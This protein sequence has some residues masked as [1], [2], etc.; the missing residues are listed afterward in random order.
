MSSAGTGK[1]A[2]KKSKVQVKMEA[3]NKRPPN[4]T[5]EEDVLISR[6]FV[7]VSENPT[8]GVDQKAADFWRHVQNVFQALYKDADVQVEDEGR[9]G[10]DSQAIRNRF[11][12]HI[13]REVQRWNS[14]YKNIKQKKR[15]GAR[16]EDII[17]AATEE[18]LDIEGKPFWFENCV[19][20]LQEMPKFDPMVAEYVDEELPSEDDK[21]GAAMETRKVAPKVNQI[22]APMGA[23]KVR[24]IGSKTAKKVLL[25]E[26]SDAAFAATA[27]ADATARTESMKQMADA[28]KK[29][30]E[31][32]KTGSSIQNLMKMAEMYI[33]VGDLAQGKS[34]LEKAKSL[35]LSQDD[36]EENNEDSSTGSASIQDYLHEQHVARAPQEG[37]EDDNSSEQS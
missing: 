33:N 36:K 25:K 13:Q 22:S 27:S 10:R 28:T 12:R 24:P 1:K 31:S 37:E 11:Q 35:Q 21:D 9:F 15:S 26:Y 20:I 30:A 8:V 14:F 17:K 4:F 18:F 5:S 2:A 29:L 7:H 3:I 32:I 34:L 16:E 23:G 6:A 19:P